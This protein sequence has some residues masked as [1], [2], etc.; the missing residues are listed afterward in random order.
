LEG[1]DEERGSLEKKVRVEKREKKTKG[2]RA[3]LLLRLSFA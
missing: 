1:E 3:L 2:L